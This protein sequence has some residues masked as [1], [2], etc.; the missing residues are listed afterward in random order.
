MIVLPI[1]SVIN[2]LLYDETI[3]N[4]SYKWY[5]RVCT[6]I[7]DSRMYRFLRQITNLRTVFGKN[8][9]IELQPTMTLK[10]ET[11]KCVNQPGTA[12]QCANQETERENKYGIYEETD[13]TSC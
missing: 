3:R 2:P 9:R 12:N 11:V 10:D 1:N 6:E 8:S 13:I 7:G 5:G 4:I